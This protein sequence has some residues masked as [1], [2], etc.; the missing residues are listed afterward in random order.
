MDHNHMARRLQQR[1]LRQEET[2]DAIDE[3]ETVHMMGNGDLVTKTTAA[4]AKDGSSN[5]IKAGASV[6]SNTSNETANNNFKNGDGIGMVAATKKP[7]LLSKAYSTSSAYSSSRRKSASLRWLYSNKSE[8]RTQDETTSFESLLPP[9]TPPS[10]KKSSSSIKKQVS[11]GSNNNNDGAGNNNG[12][13]SSNNVVVDDDNACLI[14][15]AE[16]LSI[17][18]SKGFQVRLPQF[19]YVL[20]CGR[21]SKGGDWIWKSSRSLIQK[22]SRELYLC[23]ALSLWR[24]R[25]RELL[26]VQSPHVFV[27]RAGFSTTKLQKL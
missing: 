2:F 23:L 5:R 18:R 25:E 13:G 16:I 17:E 9:P 26:V 7:S 6:D 20:G 19:D 1:L 3:I 15:F 21:S 10:L 24:R 8:S 12:N 27:P 11:V 22:L 4:P 14:G